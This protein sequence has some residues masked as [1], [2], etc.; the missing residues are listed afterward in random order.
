VMLCPFRCADRAENRKPQGPQPAQPQRWGKEPPFW[1][2]AR[3]SRF[4]EL[5]SH[6]FL[7]HDILEHHSI[8]SN[9]LP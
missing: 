3:G 8:E 6:H 4:P 5:A 2:W 9:L 7:D 1:G